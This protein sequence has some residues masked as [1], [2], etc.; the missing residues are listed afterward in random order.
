MKAR[1]GA[2]RHAK[3]C[4]VPKAHRV[5]CDAVIDLNVSG[6]VGAGSTPEGYGP[7]DLQAAY[8][9][10][11]TDA[12]DRTVAVVDAY[13]LPSAEADLGVYRAK[14]G[15]PPCTTGNGCFSKVNQS[16][17]G[18]PLPAVNTSWGQEIDLDLAMVSAACPTCKILLVEASNTSQT[19]LGTAVDTAVSLG[20]S[21]VSNSYGG[22]ESSSE[23]QADTDYYN[24]PGVA[25][26][27]SAGDSGFGVSYPAASPYVIAVGGTSLTKDS[28]SRGFSESAWD[29]TG[30]GCSD[31]EPKPSWQHDTGCV[32]RTVADVSADADPATGVA[33]YDSTPND[34]QS[35]WLVAG[36][37]SASAPFVAGVYTLSESVTNSN[38]PAA[39][40][41]A[42][43]SSLW[44]VTTGA[45]GGCDPAYL[46]SAVK[47]YDGPTGLGTPSGIAAFSGGADSINPAT[48]GAPTDVT[49]T[50][51]NDQA[52]VSWSAPA[53]SGGSP[54]VGYVVTPIRAGV[55]M[56]AHAYSTTATMQTITG[57]NAG[58]SYTFTVAAVNAVGR[59]A[60]SSPS[61]AVVPTDPIW[62]Y[63]QHLGGAASFLSTP[64]AGDT[65]A[66]GGGLAQDFRGGSVYWSA[67]TGAHAVRGAIL[68]KY[69]GL[70]GPAGILGYPTTDQT[71]S[72]DKV[73]AYNTF[74]GSGGASI[75]WSPK[76]NAHDVYG[77]IRT[78]WASTGAERGPLGYPTTDEATEP[79]G[80]GRQVSFAGLGGAYL[81]WSPA[82]GAHEVLGAILAKYRAAG[83]PKS[84]LSYPTTDETRT[85][86]GVGRY[87]KFTWGSIYW[88]P[89]TGAH[90]VSLLYLTVWASLG[91][92]HGWLGYPTS[93][94]YVIPGGRRIN[95]QHGYLT[96]NA[97]AGGVIATH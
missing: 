13:D 52:S 43:T 24:H 87:N 96:Y 11:A 63:Y 2:H 3:V 30:S 85:A 32:R 48:P 25:I 38:Y 41:Y 18:G 19:S 10:P 80:V 8:Q 88:S 54:V 91:A 79:D 29:G 20:A 27:A 7:A 33:V 40:P 73:G 6:N 44:D 58:V 72:L 76:T 51:G 31:Y 21:A 53:S 94:E 55:A 5:S 74:A 65:T 50:T 83:G 26:T 89:K 93:D 16:G 12:D 1:L 86:D 68:A 39:A 92:E 95:F 47:G 37:T 78:K 69:K 17:A 46:C 75:Y 34:G 28:S 81:Y 14:Y 67:A 82:T 90:I 56:P 70:G 61:A 45:N 71:A 64:L 9:L 35:G 60:A 77:A 23:W 66:P 42:H 62:L 57:L 36:G 15:L 4:G 49:A 59:G 97:W 84:L 22:P